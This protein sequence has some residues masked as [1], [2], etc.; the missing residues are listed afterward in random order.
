MQRPHLNR[1]FEASGGIILAADAPAAL[2]PDLHPWVYRL[3]RRSPNG[4]PDC[5]HFCPNGPVVSAWTLVLANM[6]QE[7]GL[8]EQTSAFAEER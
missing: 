2:R 6:V 5:L 1:L 8:L 4:F 3:S 7:W